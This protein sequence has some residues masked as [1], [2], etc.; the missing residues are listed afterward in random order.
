MVSFTKVER[1]VIRKNFARV[2][3]GEVN[4]ERRLNLQNRFAVVRASV[5]RDDFST[6]ESRQT[7]E[8]N[9]KLIEGIFIIKPWPIYKLSYN[10]EQFTDEALMKPIIAEAL[11]KVRCQETDF[12]CSHYDLHSFLLS[13]QVVKHLIPDFIKSE[14]DKE[15]CSANCTGTCDLQTYT[16]PQYLRRSGHMSEAK[17][18]VPCP[19][20]RWAEYDPFVVFSSIWV[21]NFELYALNRREN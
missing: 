6:M 9:L 4:P 3:N 10:A 7:L 8:E 16:M 17:E 5:L 18:I 1:K 13:F 19:S 2:E 11:K 21:S 20:R 15:E 14:C 12:N